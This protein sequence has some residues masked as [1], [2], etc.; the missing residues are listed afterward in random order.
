MIEK[1]RLGAQ[2]NEQKLLKKE[3]KDSIIRRA[4]EA[5]FAKKIVIHTYHFTYARGRAIVYA[6]RGEIF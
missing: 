3:K 4:T 1:R 6:A 5:W 2:K